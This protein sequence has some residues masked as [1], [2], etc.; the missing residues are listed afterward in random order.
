MWSMQMFAILNTP[1][2]IGLKLLVEIVMMA[3]KFESVNTELFLQV[4]AGRTKR[5]GGT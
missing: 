5:S 3:C 1:F 4:L 2:K